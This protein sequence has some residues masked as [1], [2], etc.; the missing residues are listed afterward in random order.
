M[1]A[2]IGSYNTLPVVWF[3]IS[4]ISFRSDKGP[5]FS[6]LDSVT[7]ALGMLVSIRWEAACA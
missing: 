3:A 4:E 5:D 7:S 2:Y 1:D 6:A